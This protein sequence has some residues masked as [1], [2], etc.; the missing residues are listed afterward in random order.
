M[1]NF[2]IISKRKLELN[3]YKNIVIKFPTNYKFFFDNIWKNLYRKK[4]R[5]S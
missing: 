3:F 4:Y 2:I 5:E 1:N